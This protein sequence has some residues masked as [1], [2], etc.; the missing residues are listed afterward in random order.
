MSQFKWN[1]V[2]SDD[3]GFVDYYLIPSMDVRLMIARAEKI[4]LEHELKARQQWQLLLP[5]QR[6]KENITY[7]LALL[8]REFLI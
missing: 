2:P 8:E 3:K 4:K 5:N 7:R 6:R 1:E